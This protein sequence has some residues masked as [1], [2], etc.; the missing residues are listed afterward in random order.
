MID[1]DQMDA[2]LDRALTDLL[3][4][5]ARPAWPP[6]GSAESASVPSSRPMGT[7]DVRPELL[8]LARFDDAETLAG[9]T[10]DSLD[11]VTRRTMR[12]LLAGRKDAVRSGLDELWGLARV[13]DDREALHRYWVQRWWAAVEWGS[14]AERFDVLDHCRERAYRFDE[15]EWWGNLTLL[16]A[17]ME[18]HDEA[19]RAFDVAAALVGR[20]PIHGHRRDVVTNLIEGAAL[21]GDTGR[22][23]KASRSLVASEGRL[24]IVGAGVVCKGSVDRYLAL[25]FAAQG[26]WADASRSFRSAA[27]AHR[28]LSAAPLLARTLR[29]AEQA[30]LAA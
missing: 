4:L 25:G 3:E 5:P 19:C 12:A 26:R 2:Q 16:L 20:A 11:A 22:V 24:V 29:Q 27:D 9:A 15:F 8:E 7:E 18:K 30:S 10:A 6:L 21:L 17:T 28:A 13:G 14:E 23:V 1:L